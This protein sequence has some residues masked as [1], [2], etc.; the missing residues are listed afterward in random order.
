MYVFM[1]TLGALTGASLLF[2]TGDGTNCGTSVSAD[3]PPTLAPANRFSVHN[4]ILAG[5]PLL[6]LLGGLPGSIE[7]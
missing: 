7:S 5:E 6:Q 1:D 4:N 2:F 3:L